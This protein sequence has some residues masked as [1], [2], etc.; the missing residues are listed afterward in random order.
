[1]IVSDVVGNEIATP[2]YGAK[3]VGSYEVEFSATSG[4][5]PSSRHGASGGNAW[6]LPSGTY[7]YRIVAVGPSAGSPQGQAEQS[8][9]E[10]KKRFCSSNVY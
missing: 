3:P 2:V 1:M 8:F 5:L 7:I 10:T 6:N 9:V 4:S